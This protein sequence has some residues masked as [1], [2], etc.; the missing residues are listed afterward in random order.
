M[1]LN[2]YA[3]LAI[4]VRGHG[5]NRNPFETGFRRAALR[6]DIRAAVDFM[7][8]S[9]RVDS[10]RIVVMGHSMGAN[11]VLDYAE[12]DPDLKGAVMI[13]GGWS[14]GEARPKNALFIFAQNDPDFIRDSSIAVAS[15]LAG[16]QPIDLGKIYGDF[17]QGTAIE[18]LQIPGV[19]H[20][21]ILSSRETARSIVKWLDGS[22]GLS[23]PNEIEL[24]D[25][26]LRFA[27]FAAFLFLILLVPIGRIAG[28]IANAWSEQAAGTD[29]LIGLV[30]LTVA[31]LVV[32]PLIAN[33]APAS[34]LSLVIGENEISWLGSAGVIIV[35]VLVSRNRLDWSRFRASVWPTLLAAALAFA[36]IFVCQNAYS[37]TFHRL[38]MTPERLLAWILATVI[39]L[40]FWLGFEFLVR[41][42]GVVISTVLGTLGRA[43]IIIL[44]FAGVTVGVFS[45]VVFLIV[46]FIVLQFVQL[47]ILAASAYSA[48]RNL[49]LIALVESA[50]FAE[51]IAATNP[52]TFML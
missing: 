51:A 26:R 12:N 37:V 34:F 6:S 30:I 47:E 3:V 31:L 38:A 27:A 2:G 33:D 20:I 41:R 4:D 32:M 44:L 19:N 17:G 23:R 39:V 25:P 5:A 21:R 49:F 22:M 35:A 11:A 50:W 48:S 7:R 16:V 10:S 45:G 28:G 14:L 18:A 36:A 15:H 24:S 46:P 43:I 42:G 9:D 29:A 40:P 52:I 8:G 13:S 1:A